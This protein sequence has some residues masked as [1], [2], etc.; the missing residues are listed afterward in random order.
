MIA[1]FFPCL[2]FFSCWLVI[3]K[4]KLPFH[5]LENQLDTLECVICYNVTPREEL[6]KIRCCIKDVCKQCDEIWKDT[7]GGAYKCMVCRK[8]ISSPLIATIPLSVFNFLYRYVTSVFN[9]ARSITHRTVTFLK[10][11]FVSMYMFMWIVFVALAL[12]CVGSL[13]VMCF[14]MVNCFTLCKITMIW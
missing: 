5:D 8:Q 6:Y 10:D 11:V 7:T 4:L 1:F 9:Q 3:M 14:M 2:L 12:L 13:I